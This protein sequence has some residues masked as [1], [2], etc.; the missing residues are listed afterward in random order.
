MNENHTNL[1]ENPQN[2]GFS[3]SDVL[4]VLGVLKTVLNSSWTNWLKHIYSLST[5]TVMLIYDSLEERNN[6]SPQ[7]SR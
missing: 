6:G 1:L 2:T 7:R 3:T 5:I 4:V